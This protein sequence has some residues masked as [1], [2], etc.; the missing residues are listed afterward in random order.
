MLMFDIPNT[1]KEEQRVYR[2]FRKKIIRNGFVMFQE[3]VYFKVLNDTAHSAG[4]I[5]AIKSYAPDNA[6]ISA[7]PLTMAEF[8]NI[9]NISGEILDVSLYCDDLVFI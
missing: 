7:I 6:A 8:L 9:R 3:S 4:Q 1:S 2:K 5:E